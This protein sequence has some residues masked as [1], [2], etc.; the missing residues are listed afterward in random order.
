[1]LT[2][3][4]ET[5]RLYVH[6]INYP[7]HYFRLPGFKGKVKYAQF[8]HDASELL[9]SE[10]P[11]RYPATMKFPGID[12]E[13]DLYLLLPVEKPDTEIPVIELILY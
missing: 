6:L 7:V 5:N 13:N 10:R 1:L 4:P 12:E 2:Y 8:L 9:F 3:N 11:A